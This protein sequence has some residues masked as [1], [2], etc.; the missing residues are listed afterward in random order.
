MEVT[1]FGMSTYPAMTDLCN[2]YVI[3]SEL[4]LGKVITKLVRNLYGVGINK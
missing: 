2:E 4:I 1:E 3:S